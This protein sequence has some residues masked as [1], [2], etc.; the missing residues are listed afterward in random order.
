MTF[1]L[2]DEELQD[3]LDEDEDAKGLFFWGNLHNQKQAYFHNC[4]QQMVEEKQQKRLQKA[5]TL[6]GHF[7]LAAKDT[8][9]YHQEVQEALALASSSL[10]DEPLAAAVVGKKRKIFDKPDGHGEESEVDEDEID[11]NG[12]TQ[13]I[14][15]LTWLHTGK[16]EHH[17]L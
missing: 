17:V 15:Y 16:K 3:D 1:V 2:A 12:P 4:Y 6:K 10:S 8:K 13:S 14:E 9:K 7:L 5:K 11:I